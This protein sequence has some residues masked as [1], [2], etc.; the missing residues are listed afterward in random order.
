MLHIC[1]EKATCIEL[2]EE[3]KTMRFT[4]W[5]NHLSRPC[6]V[7]ADTESSTKELKYTNGTHEHIPNSAPFVFT[8]AYEHTQ[9][10][11][12]S[13]VGE[14]CIRRMFI[15]LPR[16]ADEC[17]ERFD[18]INNQ[19]LSADEK[20]CMSKCKTTVIYVIINPQSTIQ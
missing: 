10:G 13:H 16:L 20:L 4:S 12:W 17:L 3:G 5:K 9:N 7:Y 1:K 18:E 11:Y 8:C 14:D 6:I 15:E 2:L 19:E